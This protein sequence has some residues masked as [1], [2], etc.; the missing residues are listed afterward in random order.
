MI[1]NR[2][3][4]SMVEAKAHLKE[5]KDNTDV[6]GFL[7]KFV[8]MKLPKAKELRKKLEGFEL[9]QVND[10]HLAKIIDLLPETKE[11][12]NKILVDT[13]LNEDETKK[14]LDVIKEYK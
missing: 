6:E 12:L 7:N 13:T 11:E 8:K 5:S 3:A 10:L 2:E 1:K 9:I 14:I 4:L